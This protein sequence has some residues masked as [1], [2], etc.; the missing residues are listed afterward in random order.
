MKEKILQMMR[1][2]DREVV[3]LGCSLWMKHFSILDLKGERIV[4]RHPHGEPI[5][6]GQIPLNCGELNLAHR[7]LFIHNN[8]ALLLYPNYV[9]LILDY[10]MLKVKYAS[11]YNSVTNERK[12]I[13][14]REDKADDTEP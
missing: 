10:D 13:Y 2:S 9:Y 6:C 1:S 4:I 8:E 3:E 5:V 11:D 12:F 14:E 7:A